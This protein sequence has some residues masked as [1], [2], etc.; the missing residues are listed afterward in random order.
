M[1]NNKI[2]IKIRNEM[3]ESYVPDAQEGSMRR[4]ANEIVARRQVRAS[5]AQYF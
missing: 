1:I 3:F 2:K 4:V 5:T